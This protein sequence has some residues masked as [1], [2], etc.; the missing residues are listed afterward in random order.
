MDG[1]TRSPQAKA[2]HATIDVRDTGR[3]SADPILLLMKQIDR[4]LGR[5][6]LIQIMITADL[7][8]FMEDPPQRMVN[9]ADASALFRTAALLTPE[10][11]KTRL[12]AAAGVQSA[13]HL[14]RHRFRSS[15]PD[16]AGLLPK[17]LVS[18]VLAS[19]LSHHAWYFIPSARFHYRFRPTL[20]L[21]LHDNPLPSPN[22]LWHLAFF[23][24]IYRAICGSGYK[25]HHHQAIGKNAMTDVFRVSSGPTDITYQ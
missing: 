22:G 8:H 3:V 7:F 16:I 11:K 18:S 19:S 5:D 21:K 17:V 6:L 24:T 1:V 4:S 9:E 13:R 20:E 23:D 2:Y 10:N 14:M 25:F 15:L 12:F